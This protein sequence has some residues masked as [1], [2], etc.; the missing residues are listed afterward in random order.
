MLHIDHIKRKLL[1]GLVDEC[2]QTVVRSTLQL[3][4]TCYDAWFAEVSCVGDM[5][6]SSAF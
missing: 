3:A 1:G 4:V 2:L 5:S 6:V